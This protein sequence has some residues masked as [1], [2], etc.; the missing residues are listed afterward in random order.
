LFGCN[1][2]LKFDVVKLRALLTARVF[3]EESLMKRRVVRESTETPDSS[4]DSR[5]DTAVAIVELGDV[6]QQRQ[7]MLMLESTNV[8][9]VTNATTQIRRMLS[10]ERDPPIDQV[11]ALNVLPRLVQYTSCAEQYPKLALEALW[12]ITNIARYLCAARG[13]LQFMYHS[14]PRAAARQRKRAPS[15]RPARC[16]R[17]SAHSL[18]LL[19]M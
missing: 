1:Q 5:L 11:L 7:L 3:A 10:I 17:W 6:A 14:K 15:S 19:K 13:C 16:R 8:D 2:T 12:A 9:D 18:R 4:E